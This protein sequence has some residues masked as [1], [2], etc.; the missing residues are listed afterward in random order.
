[1][2]RRLSESLRRAPAHAQDIR[3][4]LV[5]EALA[6]STID[7]QVRGGLEP[8]LH[9]WVACL[10][11]V[12]DDDVAAHGRKAPTT[13]DEERT[14]ARCAAEVAVRVAEASAGARH[15]RASGK[16]PTPGRLA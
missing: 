14:V 6:G 12:V 15:E 10:G 3:K 5:A 8:P 13:P 2:G 4:E 11:L 7:S 16:P 1:V 9:G